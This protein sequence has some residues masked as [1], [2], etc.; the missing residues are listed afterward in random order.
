[1]IKLLE[2][3]NI[4]GLEMKNKIVL[5]PMTMDLATEDG[6]VTEKVK[7]HY[8]KMANTG[9]GAI[10]LENHY[11]NIQGKQSERQLAIDRDECIQGLSEIA[12]IIHKNKVV[13]GVQINHAGSAAHSAITGHKIIAP[14]AI[15]HPKGTEVPDEMTTEEIENVKKQ[16][17]KAAGRVKKAGFDFVEIHGCHGYL[18]NQFL[19]PLTNTRIDE[20]GGIRANRIKFPIEIVK[21]IREEVGKDFLIFYRIAAADNMENG[22]TIDDA[23]YLAVKLVEAGVDVLD[24]SQGLAGSR[25]VTNQQGFFVHL[26]EGIKSVVRIP[27]ITTG[28]IKEGLF[29]HHVIE[30]GKADMIGV[31]RAILQDDQWVNTIKEELKD[32]R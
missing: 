3:I 29:A 1:M 26:S 22:L 9:V 30:D 15:I 14:S 6:L 2:P 19:S 8:K 17:R 20:Y 10:I 5:P 23:K 21:E 25:P 4:R 28:G 27:V 32:V 11:I 31:G 7:D 12:D 24:V 16:F 18:L 13:C